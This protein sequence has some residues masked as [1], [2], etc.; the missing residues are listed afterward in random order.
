MKISSEV[1]PDGR[2]ASITIEG[3]IQSF[4]DLETPLTTLLNENPQLAQVL[5]DLT[6]VDA[7]SILPRE[8]LRIFW[9]TFNHR[10]RKIPGTRLE[11]RV[12]ERVREIFELAGLTQGFAGIVNFTDQYHEEQ[13]E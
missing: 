9:N 3:R 13:G 1:S 4:D 8:Q 2:S 6:S 10:T 5:M 7:I 12:S 11:V